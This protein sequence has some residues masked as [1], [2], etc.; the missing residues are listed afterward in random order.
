MYT[1]QNLL[2]NMT[3]MNIDPHGAL[4]VHLSYKAIGEVE[5]G[6]ETVL[7]ALTEYM[8][9]G[10][11][12]L[13][14]H[15]WRNVNKDNPVMDVLYTP[16]CVGICTDL[17]RRRPG[18]W[19]SFHPTHSV[20]ALGKD[21][22]EFISGEEKIQP[23][24]GK[25]GVYCKLWE[26]DA[27][28]LLIG[29]NFTRN[30]FIHGIEEWD[31]ATGTISKEKTDL[32]VIDHDGGRIYTP[33]YRHCAPL[34]SE[35][36]VKLEPDMLTQGVMAISQFGDATARLMRAKPLRTTTAALLAKNPQY[37]LRH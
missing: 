11:L 22:Q 27:Q 3:A 8:K 18:V 30:T 31:G 5:N 7:D 16:A 33:Q 15:S 37:L 20:A 6:V 13:P 28:I 14:S 24:C 34:S 36:F 19:R 23:P 2:D 26:R 25:N 29:V 21:A 32:Y 17:F 4:M 10:L 1:K 12:V 35:T 9:D